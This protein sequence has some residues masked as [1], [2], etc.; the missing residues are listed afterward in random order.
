MTETEIAYVPL[1]FT[2]EG[3]DKLF[4]AKSQY[5]ANPKLQ[6][7]IPRSIEN[8][9]KY[10]DPVLN[11]ADLGAITCENKSDLNDFIAELEYFGLL[12]TV[13]TEN[14]I[15]ISINANFHKAL[16]KISNKLS[17][18]YDTKT[19][20]M[21]TK[22]TN[23]KIMMNLY[24]LMLKMRYP[25][26]EELTSVNIDTILKMLNGGAIQDLMILNFKVHNL[27]YEIVELFINVYMD[28]DTSLINFDFSPSLDI[29]VD[30]TALE[31]LFR[32]VSRGKAPN[33]KRC[34]AKSK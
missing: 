32:S 30:S 3:N 27:V 1:H 2:C 22:Y 29:L 8:Y 10:V 21:K 23:K 16:V 34:L 7:R 12:K 20:L 5:D 4:V 28:K 9:K 15:G 24:I 33:M 26:S 17:K 13:S 11:G 6:G 25:D 31:S 18:F 19:N 14:I